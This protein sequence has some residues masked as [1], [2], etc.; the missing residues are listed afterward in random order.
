MRNIKY[1]DIF[2]IADS[3]ANFELIFFSLPRIPRG[4]SLFFT[5]FFLVN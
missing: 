1:S 3:L 5:R 2:Y 4:K